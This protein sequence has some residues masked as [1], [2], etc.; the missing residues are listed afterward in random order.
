MTSGFIQAALYARVSSEQ[1]ASAQTIAS[2][3]AALQ[4]RMAADAC[5][6]VPE[7]LFIDEGY[8]GATLVRPA[9]ERLRDAVAVGSVGRLYVHSPDRLARKYAYQV[10][11][12]DEF[13][14]AGVEVVFL[15]RAVG[16]NPEDELLL[17]VQGMIAEY[18]RA[19]I[20]ER[21]RRGKRHQAH[22][23]AV[24]VLSGA[25]YGY[26][27]CSRWESGGE[28]RYELIPEEAQVV[29][30]IFAWVGQ[31][32]LSLGE[33][34][35][36]LT[37][38]GV[39]TRAGKAVWDRTTL[40]GLLKNPAYCGHAAFGKTRV[41][42]ARARLRPMRGKSAEPRR[43]HGV[44]DV[45]REEWISIAV[46]AIVT[47]ELFEA[48]H[49]QLQ[50]NQRR[51]RTGQRGARYLLQG[52][53]TCACCGYAFYGKAISLSAG[54][55]QRR[56]YAYYRCIGTDAYRFGGQRVCHNLQV[57]TDRLETAVWSEVKALLADPQR[58]HSEYQR[59]LETAA[60]AE[61]RS[62]AEA[63]RAQIQRLHQ[64]C[65]RLLDG[66]TEGYI[67][68]GEFVP[69]YEGLKQ[70]IATLDE[71]ARQLE[72]VERQVAQLRLVIGR[73]E[74]F[75][76]Q[77]KDGLETMP[78]SGRREVIRTLVKRVDIGT[79]EVNVVFRVMPGGSGS[80]SDPESGRFLQHCGRRGQSG[81]G[82]S[83]STL[84]V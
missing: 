41:G 51:A 53:V 31:E 57:R 59:R 25:P 17:Q 42:P 65:R 69:R 16:Q 26:R 55:G 4:A 3:V 38:A 80:G 68:K 2:Q 45:P 73:L 34:R 5:D 58:L 6:V 33:V 63:L 78:W 9:L 49:E 84:H 66:Y 50:E 13:Q 67:D 8:S 27:Y 37:A 47:E 62:T 79:E 60:T 39:P 75:A 10:L 64:G 74:D 46:P 82:Q 19:K 44:Y 43:H 83:V 48:V 21:S 14:R 61:Q 36:R 40:W 12:I 28:A 11:L 76:A 35:R 32:R 54:K 81:A 70:R 56:D 15:N 23:G 7:R 72:D 20:L 52:L 30:Q 1:Q 18:E 77:V 24:N 22:N 71:Q 29:R